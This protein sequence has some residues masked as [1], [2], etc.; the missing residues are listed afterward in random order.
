[1]Y[2]PEGSVF[3]DICELI[4][5]VLGE[6]EPPLIDHQMYCKCGRSWHGLPAGTC[7]GSHITGEGVPALEMHCDECGLE[8]VG[9]YDSEEELALVL[10]RGGWSSTAGGCLCPGC[11]AQRACA[12]SG[13]QW[14]EI[15][16]VSRECDRC[17]AVD[18]CPEPW[19]VY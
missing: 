3:D 4:T 11:R 2:G 17:C 5:A 18:G 15:D 12:L 10:D 7:P 1:M 9:A 19:V 13:H 6:G 16:L 14:V 8:L